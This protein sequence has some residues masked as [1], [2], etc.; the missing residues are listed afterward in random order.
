MST[1]TSDSM[2]P[3]ASS[4]LIQWATLTLYSH[5][6]SVP[7]TVSDLAHPVPA[8]EAATHQA[9][10]TTT[11][12]VVVADLV[13]SALAEMI[14]AVAHH[15]ATTTPVVMIVM[16]VLHLVARLVDVTTMAAHHADMTIHTL[17]HHAALRT[18][19]HT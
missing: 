9:H 19:I 11:M 3:D 15:L 10:Q 16:D 1:F 12:T 8:L 6:K 7:E 14:T 17:H 5:R 4:F 18:T 13:A 2:C